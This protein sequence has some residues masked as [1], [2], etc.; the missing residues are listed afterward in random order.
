MLDNGFPEVRDAVIFTDPKGKDHAALVTA[1][2]GQPDKGK[3]VAVNLVYVSDEENRRDECGR[4][5]M[6]SSSVCHVSTMGIA[7]GYY[8]RWSGEEKRPYVAPGSI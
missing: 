2:W 4:Q 3:A 5:L 8:W 1:T 7:H 6:R